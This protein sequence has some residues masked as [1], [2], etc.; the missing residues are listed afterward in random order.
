MDSQ[1]DTNVSEK[2][3]VSIFRA[4]D[5]KKETVFNPEDGDSMFIRDVCIYPRVYTASHP[6]R[7]SSTSPP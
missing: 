5:L 1:V 2:H 3:I 7:T 4:E 6:R